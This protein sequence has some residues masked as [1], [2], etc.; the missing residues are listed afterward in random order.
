[1]FY[2][3]EGVTYNLNIKLDEQMIVQLNE[4]AGFIMQAQILYD[5]FPIEEIR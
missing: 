1:M 2:E 3:R 4:S 5:S